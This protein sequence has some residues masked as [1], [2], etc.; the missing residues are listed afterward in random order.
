MMLSERRK[1]LEEVQKLISDGLKTSDAIAK[2]GWTAASYYKAKSVAAKELNAKRP[3]FIDVL[4]HPVAPQTV[5]L[6]VC[7]PDQISSVLRG[8]Q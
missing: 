8:L 4:A 5:V 6:V 3:K 1:K 7:L 2:A